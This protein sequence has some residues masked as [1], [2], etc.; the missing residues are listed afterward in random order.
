MTH[1]CKRSCKASQ[2]KRS[3]KTSQVFVDV[4][5]RPSA[6][7]DS[8]FIEYTYYVHENHMPGTYW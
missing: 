4:T 1:H 2:C 6:S 5:P 3:C 8:N 7:A